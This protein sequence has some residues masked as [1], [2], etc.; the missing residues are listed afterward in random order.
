M[1]FNRFRL[2]YERRRS[3]A[4]INLVFIV[5]ATIVGSLVSVYPFFVIQGSSP[6]G[7][8]TASYLAHMRAFQ[9]EE[10]LDKPGSAYTYVVIGV[11][12][13]NAFQIPIYEVEKIL[14]TILSALVSPLIYIL[15]FRI[16]K[17]SWF[18]LASGLFAAVWF[19]KLRMFRDLHDNLLGIDIFIIILILLYGYYRKT[20]SNPSETSNMKTFVD[21]FKSYRTYFVIFLIWLLG[22]SHLAS[23]VFLSLVM[24]ILA[25]TFN[26]QWKQLGLSWMIGSIALGVYISAFG[27]TDAVAED[28]LFRIIVGIVEPE[29]EFVSPDRVDTVLINVDNTEENIVAF[30]DP[31]SVLQIPL[32]HIDYLQFVLAI[33]G[34]ALMAIA[35]YKNFFNHKINGIAILLSW[36]IAACIMILISVTT[37]LFDLYRPLLLVPVPI[38]VPYSLFWIY[39]SILKVFGHLNTDNND[40]NRGNSLFKTF[41][42]YLSFRV[43]SYQA[44]AFFTIIILT[45]TLLLSGTSRAVSYQSRSPLWIND[46]LVE[47][48]RTIEE[49]RNANNEE[50]VPVIILTNFP[51]SPLGAARGGVTVEHIHHTV[52]SVIGPQAQL[53]LGKISYFEAGCITPSENAGRYAHSEFYFRNLLGVKGPFD[54]YYIEY[55]NPSP[56]VYERTRLS[57]LSDRVFMVNS[58]PSAFCNLNELDNK[59]DVFNGSFEFWEADKIID[60]NVNGVAEKSSTITSTGNSSLI[61]YPENEIYRQIDFFP[62]MI[63]LE[64]YTQ[65]GTDAKVDIQ[66]YDQT[67]LI[68]YHLTNSGFPIRDDGPLYKTA[69][70]FASNDNRW[71]LVRG[72]PYTDWE[73]LYDE[74][75]PTKTFIYIT[76]RGIDPVI[77]DDLKLQERER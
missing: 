76:N 65:N 72:T 22:I 11:L 3:F 54:G 52:R 12:I 23:Y 48:L 51:D 66:I 47:Q 27:Y 77:I 20:A 37:N 31:I 35:R 24:G 30:A 40:R 74:E 75:P 39:R 5:L 64:V 1:G 70:T 57:E 7:W 10:I 60:W 29:D 2:L 4:S 42:M 33:S 50:S 71:N 73:E 26:R 38:L 9:S 61:L 45:S 59:N 13:S 16:F 36:A 43:T 58:P 56:T 55:L 44:F 41:Q 46:E 49:Y 19:G 6:I 21:Y 68:A 28:V 69:G 17:N 63:A 14:P 32:S 34:I 62:D 8:D 25:I 15:T 18:S 67:K 53:Y